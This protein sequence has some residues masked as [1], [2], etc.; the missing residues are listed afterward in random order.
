MEVRCRG[1]GKAWGTVKYW[2]VNSANVWDQNNMLQIERSLK[3]WKKPELP[4]N[5]I[6]S[7]KSKITTY[8]LCLI[9]YIL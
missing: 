6:F 8:I 9:S 4:E 1:D 3:L 5:T 2:G 7:E